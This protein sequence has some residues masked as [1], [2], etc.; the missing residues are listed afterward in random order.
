MRYVFA[1][2]LFIHGIIHIMGFIKAFQSSD[3]IKPTQSVSKPIGFLWLFVYVL[4][5]VATLFYLFEEN[6][7]FVLAFTAVI[8]SQVLIIIYWKVAKFGSI[9]NLV[10]LVVSIVAYSSYQFSEMIEKESIELLQNI[11]EANNSDD[12]KNRVEDLP[13]IVQKWLNNSGAI[14]KGEKR[15]VHLEQIGEMRNE[16]KS[17]WMPF[18]ANQYI[19]TINPGFLW[20]AK[21]QA[22]PFV[23]IYGRDKLINGKGEMLIKLS[24]LVTIENEKENEK[25]DS[26]AMLRFLSEICWVPSVALNDCI[27]WEAINST[28]AK[29]TLIINNKSVAG[30]FNFN[31]EGEILSFETNR[32][33]G[34][35]KEAKQEQ[36][37][38]KMLSY[39]TFNAIK[40][41]NKCKVIWKL[42]EGDFNWLNLE[43]TDMDYNSPLTFLKE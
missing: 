25:I 24:T 42:A 8:V 20:T 19:N 23:T 10:I 33:Y 29:A 9:A 16:P 7:W 39:K 11:E 17:K 27:K 30:V 36:W 40:I 32:Y 28:S 5:M 3:S 38:V 18:L 43:V 13:L 6:W 37:V 14:D 1:F 2:I 4:F 31:D 41:P 21:V 35:E 34:G 22:M 26:G 15:V 12:N